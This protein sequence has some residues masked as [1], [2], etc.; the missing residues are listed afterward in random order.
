VAATF[1]W[2]CGET[3]PA[4]LLFQF[5]IISEKTMPHFEGKKVG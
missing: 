1:F 2:W 5:N 3:E 4:N